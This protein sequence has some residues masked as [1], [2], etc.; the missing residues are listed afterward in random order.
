MKIKTKFHVGFTRWYLRDSYERED[1]DIPE[2]KVWDA[3][4]LKK[5]CSRITEQK[6]GF[7]DEET[8]IIQKNLVFYLL[9][10]DEFVIKNED[11]IFNFI[12]EC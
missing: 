5:W 4:D 7:T 3:S 1:V 9:N 6:K 12:K 11:N 10:K 8:A 2:S